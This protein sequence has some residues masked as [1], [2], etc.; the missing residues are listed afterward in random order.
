MGSLATRKTLPPGGR[1]LL[2]FLES[3][4]WCAPRGAR[5][6]PVIIPGK[7]AGF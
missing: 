1:A 6:T 5:R 2:K 7:T 3:R 4:W